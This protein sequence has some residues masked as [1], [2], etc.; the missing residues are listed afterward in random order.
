MPSS[1]AFKEKCF[2][3]AP[4]YQYKLSCLNQCSPYIKEEWRERSNSFKGTDS[5]IIQEP[6]LR[7]SNKRSCSRAS[8]ISTCTQRRPPNLPSGRNNFK[9]NTQLN[10][11][12]GPGTQPTQDCQYQITPAILDRSSGTE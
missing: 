9:K 2:R 5:K 12:V 7:C 8:P 11:R 1:Q 10:S 6:W 4:P 3:Q